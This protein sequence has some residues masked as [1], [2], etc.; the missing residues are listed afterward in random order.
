MKTLVTAAALV[1]LV[2]CA[3][4][5]TPPSESASPAPATSAP[6]PQSTATTGSEPPRDAAPYPTSDIAD[7]QAIFRSTCVTCHGADGRKALGITLVSE[8]NQ[9]RPDDELVRALLAPTH[10][11][12]RL[13]EAQ[14]KAAIAYVKALK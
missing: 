13:N 2:S 4:T 5:E 14:A 10:P 6:A 8:A 11:E 3:K 7:G 12:V 1:L 9:K